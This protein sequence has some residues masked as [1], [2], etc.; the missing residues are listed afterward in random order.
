MQTNKTLK[1]SVAAEAAHV[2]SQRPNETD[3]GYQR[4]I[5]DTIAQRLHV[6]NLVTS[7]KARVKREQ[8]II[9]AQPPAA[10]SQ[11]WAHIEL[12]YYNQLQA[13]LAASRASEARLLAALRDLVGTSR[14]NIAAHNIAKAKA[15]AAIAQ[16]EGR[17]P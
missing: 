10:P 1:A 11:E 4:R 17:Q 13:D 16:A 12:E 7:E 5:A 9:E 8:A 2:S 14:E 6:E 3:L 15:C